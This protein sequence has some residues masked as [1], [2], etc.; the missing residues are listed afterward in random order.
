V[1][2][3]TVLAKAI[4]DCLRCG[5]EESSRVLYEEMERVY[6]DENGPGVNNAPLGIEVRLGRFP[7]IAETLGG[8]AGVQLL[9][10]IGERLIQSFDSDQCQS[11]LE[12]VIETLKRLSS[13]PQH[14]CPA[15]KVESVAAVLLGLTGAAMQKRVFRPIT[16][17]KALGFVAINGSADQKRKSWDIVRSL[18]DDHDDERKRADAIRAAQFFGNEGIG[19]LML[20]LKS[21]PSADVRKA[22][23][24]ALRDIAGKQYE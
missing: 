20:Q 5:G 2:T 7:L 11:L 1:P 4:V 21:D 10:T 22:A 19:V 16:L 6:R 23:V 9:K 17:M 15:T 12:N 24:S 8:D 14:G 13:S 18:L 3:A